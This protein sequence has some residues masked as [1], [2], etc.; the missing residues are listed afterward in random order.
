KLL[1]LSATL[2][3]TFFLMTPRSFMNLFKADA[4]ILSAFSRAFPEKAESGDSHRRENMIQ[5][6]C[7]EEASMD[8]EAAFGGFAYT[9]GGGDRGWR[10]H[11]GSRGAM[12]GEHQLGGSLPQASPR[13]GERQLGK[14]WRLQ[15]FHAGGA[16]GP[17]QAIGGRAARHHAGGARGWAG[18]EE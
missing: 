16:R 18:E 8:G 7:W 12:R 2:R 6:S 10:Y 3:A 14:V 5:A 11:P 13:N 1:I 17:C 4:F 9:G 15:G